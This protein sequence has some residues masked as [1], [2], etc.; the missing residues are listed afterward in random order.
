MPTNA[1]SVI[2]ETSAL[3]IAMVIAESV[4]GAYRPVGAVSTIHE[5]REIAASDIGRRMRRLGHGDDPMCPARYRVWAQTDGGEY[6]VVAEIASPTPPAPPL[7][8]EGAG[9]P[10]DCCPGSTPVRDVGHLEKQR[11]SALDEIHQTRERVNGNV[12]NIASGKSK[13]R[14][15]LYTIGYENLTVA[16]LKRLISRYSIS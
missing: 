12:I 4:D 14:K 2:K 5:A 11:P 9:R 15:T 3:G 7:G 10:S 1:A 6:A 13:K 16:R 8:Q